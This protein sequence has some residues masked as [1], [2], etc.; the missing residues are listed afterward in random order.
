MRR[1]PYISSVMPLVLVG[2]LG[3]IVAACASGGASAPEAR[4]GSSLNDKRGPGYRDG[5]QRFGDGA[6][7]KALPGTPEEFKSAAVGDTV[8]FSSDSVDL[9][10]EGQA[11]LV[12]Q[13]R[14]LRQYANHAI[15]IEG[16][17]DKRGTREYNI[18]LGHRRAITVKQ[19]LTTQGIAIARIRAMSFGKE[20]PVA[21]CNDI[22]CWS[23]NRRA[24]TVLNGTAV[25]R[26]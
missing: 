13:S 26:N 5:M 16:H 21:V 18:A 10:P 6:A 24:Q 1:L 23:R 2:V 8:Y 20:R 3:L 17:A 22:S 11:S 25:S 9:T 19:F 4:L 14:W 12:T 7:G 15:M